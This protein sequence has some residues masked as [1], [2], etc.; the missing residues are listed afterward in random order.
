MQKIFKA[1]REE[2]IRR[3]GA[4]SSGHDIHHLLRVQ[5]MSLRLQQKHG[6]NKFIIGVSALV[7]DVHR[8]LSEDFGQYYSPEASLPEVLEIISQA[9][10]PG[11][12]YEAI[13]H[14]VR[15]HEEYKFGPRGNPATDIET[16][17]LQDADN[18]DALGAIGL[19]RAFAYGGAYDI[20]IW[21]PDVPLTQADGYIESATDASEV[22]HIHN[23]LL[24]LKDNMN[25][26]TARRIARV[27]HAYVKKFLDQ[28][29]AEWEGLK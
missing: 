21:L 4:D 20:A 16:L 26:A 29:F 10:V 28:F 11:H 3:F 19:A 22:H 1:I 25:T 27:R 15:Y 5:K 14:C 7:H 17:I 13:C 6:G 18:L 12:F 23:K 8:L 24:R 2:I 9:N